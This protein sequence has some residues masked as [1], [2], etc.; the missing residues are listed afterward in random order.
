V[1]GSDWYVLVKDAGRLLRSQSLAASAALI[2]MY[3]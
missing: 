3:L 2:G 1:R